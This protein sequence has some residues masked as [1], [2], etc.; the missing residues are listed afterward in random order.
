MRRRKGIPLVALIIFIALLV[1]VILTCVIIL[2]TNKGKKNNTNQ[3]NVQQVT[4]TAAPQPDEPDDDKAEEITS[5]DYL[6]DDATVKNA[7][8][9]TGN[10]KTYAKY[11]IYSSGG[12]S[13]QDNNISNELKLQLA[14]AQVT[15]QDMDKDSSTK[16]VSKDKIENYASKIFEDGKVDLKDFSLYSSDTTFTDEYKTIGYKYNSSTESY[17]V[18]ENEVDEEYPPQ[19]T[20][21]VTKAVKYNN[22]LEIY[23]KPIFVVPFY[24]N[25]INAMGCEM[26]G[27]YDFQLNDFPEDSALG[28]F[29]Y[30]DYEDAFVSS[31]NSDIDGYN[32]NEISKYIDFNNIDDYK[33]TFVKVGD[34]FKLDS[35][36]KESAETPSSEQGEQQA[37]TAQEKQLFNSQLDSYEGSDIAGSQVKALLD[38]V[39]SLNESYS[40]RPEMILTVT[41]NDTTAQLEDDKIEEL[42]NKIEELK[43]DVDSSKKYTVK[44][45]YKS[46]LIS[47]VTITEK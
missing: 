1:A 2:G 20:E 18:Q 44:T 33:Y 43:D 24:S 40:N 46:G 6:N 36:S 28:A 7:Y 26:Y 32:Y 5:E 8:K 4:P 10:K 45:T 17:E 19:I 23:V 38:I 29:R 12:F 14:M 34:E 30:S 31:Y 27:N 9:L 16:S 13:S 41:V 39:I 35:F 11:A 47:K 22:K 15:N 25:E 37:L 42:N 3:N 21:V